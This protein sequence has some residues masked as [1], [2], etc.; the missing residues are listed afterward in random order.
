MPRN[1]DVRLI[2]DD[3]EFLLDLEKE[4]EGSGTISGHSLASVGG[5]NSKNFCE[6][7]DAPPPQ[8]QE[9]FLFPPSDSEDD[10]E[11]QVDKKPTSSTHTAI[12]TSKQAKEKTASSNAF[13][14]QDSD[15]DSKKKGRIARQRKTIVADDAVVPP[16]GASEKNALKPR[17]DQGTVRDAVNKSSTDRKTK[18]APNNRKCSKKA[19]LKDKCA[20]VPRLQDPGVA[21]LAAAGH[22]VVDWAP[23]P[24]RHARGF[25]V[26]GE[27]VCFP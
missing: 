9:R 16:E 11:L 2:R 21:R 10:D 12:K 6:S 27:Q 22:D 24:K 23:S 26:L 25:E 18:Q 15:S 14:S 1:R 5:K 3:V 8:P 7:D 19:D 17:C 20:K 4:P 13:E